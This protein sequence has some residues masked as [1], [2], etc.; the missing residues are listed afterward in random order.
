MGSML[1]WDLASAE[2]VRGALSEAVE[3]RARSAQ[4]RGIEAFGE[5]PDAVAQ[6]LARVGDTAMRTP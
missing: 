5:P 2:K 1:L 4:I 3:E 6:E